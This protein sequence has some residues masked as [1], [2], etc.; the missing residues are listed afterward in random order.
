MDR[1]GTLTTT[2]T[3]ELS[4]AEAWRLLALIKREMNEAEPAW[5]PYWLRLGRLLARRIELRY[6]AL[7]FCG[8]DGGGI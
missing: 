1:E 3:I 2:V 8:S 7:R 6:V 4:E 5:Q